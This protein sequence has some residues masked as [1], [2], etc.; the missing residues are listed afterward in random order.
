[1]NGSVMQF[2]AIIILLGVDSVIDIKTREIPNWISGAI[3][4]TAFLNFDVR[5]LWGLIVAVIFFAVLYLREKSAAEMS[6]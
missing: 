4:L 1:M 2:A 6:S 3:A 5:S